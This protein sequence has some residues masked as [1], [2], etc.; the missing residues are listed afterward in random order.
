MGHITQ[1]ERSMV[2]ANVHVLNERDSFAEAFT[3]E[4][5]M[6]RLKRSSAA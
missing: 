6:D 2:D 4:S 1:R 5:T 3:A